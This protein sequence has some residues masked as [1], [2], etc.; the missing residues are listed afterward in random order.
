MNRIRVAILDDHPAIADGYRYRLM[1]EEDFDVVCVVYYGEDLLPALEKQAVDILLLDMQVVVSRE[2]SASLNTIHL[3]PLIVERFPDIA[4]LVISQ[5][6]QRAMVTAMLNTGA[7][8]YVLKDDHEAYRDL[9]SLVRVIAKGG[10]YLSAR[11]RENWIRPRT[12][13]LIPTL[14][15]RQMEALSLA[16]SYPNER[17]PQL[18]VRMSF[19]P[20]PCGS[21][22]G[23]LTIAW[24]LTLG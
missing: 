2:N 3:V 13:E 18:A 24:G 1:G 23:T 5:Y 20:P 19:R 11:V 4:I 6:D 21:F 15:K 16:A 10:M 14:S 22:C 17:L 12:G 7:D 8:G 9:P